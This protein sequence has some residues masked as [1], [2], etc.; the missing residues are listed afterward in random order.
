MKKYI[1]LTSVLALT[2]CGGGS[3]SGTAPMSVGESNARITS[4]KSNSEYQIKQYVMK[5]LGSDAKSVGLVNGDTDTRAAFMPS[6][7]LNTNNDYEKIHEL[8]ELAEWL[9]N[10][11][12]TEQDIID[13][14]NASSADKNKIKS[15]L[16]LMDNMWCFVGGSATKTA[17]RVLEKRSTFAEPLADLKAKTEVFNMKDIKFSILENIDQV[18]ELRFN[19]NPK[20]GRV[21]SIEYPDAEELN[22]QG[23]DTTA[24]PIKRKGDTNFFMEQVYDDDGSILEGIVIPHEYVSYGKKLNLQYADFGVLRHHY[25]KVD[26]EGMEDWGVQDTPFAGGYTTKYITNN[27]VKDLAMGGDITFK[28]LAVGDVSDWDWSAGV[29]N[30]GAAI[31]LPGGALTD[32]NATL[33]F[34]QDGEQILTADF[35]DRWYKIQ[36]VKHANGKDQFRVLSGDGGDDARYHLASS[37]DN[38]TDG[39]NTD[40]HA[41]VFQTDYYGDNPNSPTEATGLAHYQWQHG[42]LI[43]IPS[44]G[45]HD[46]EHHLNIDLGFGGTKQE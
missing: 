20:T 30:E 14:F 36:A 8:V 11:E 26:V 41:I 15:A 16:K 27:Q 4:M 38:L 45:H 29:D 21:E 5:K 34:A 2:A 46:Y 37:P 7:V 17:E 44:K 31:P 39:M 40:Q 3:G 35:S 1:I 6:D 13:K 10:D 43:Y 23:Y 32:N 19:V 25:N 24:G 28:G 42:D 22:E 12:T 18:T 33:V 9:Y